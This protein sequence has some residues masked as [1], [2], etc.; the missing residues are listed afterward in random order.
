M[1]AND[2][3][4]PHKIAEILNRPRTNNKL[5]NKQGFNN[6]FLPLRGANKQLRDQNTNRIFYNGLNLD[7]IYNLYVNKFNES[8]PPILR[9]KPLYKPK[10]EL[11]TDYPFKSKMR[12]AEAKTTNTQFPPDFQLKPLQQLYR[13]YFSPNLGSWEIDIVVAPNPLVK[14]MNIY[15][16]FCVNINTKY[17]IVYKVE[18]RDLIHLV[19][20]I[21]KLIK[22]KYVSNIRGDGELANIKFKGINIYSNSQAN[23]N[24]NR[25]VDR[26]IRTVRDAVGLD[27]FT[28]ENNIQRVVDFYNK[29]PHNSLRYNNTLYTPEQVE[30]S[31]DL[32]GLFI[33]KNKQ[34]LDVVIQ[35]QKKAGLF[36]YKTGNI[37]LVHLDLS[38]TPLM[39]QK[40]RRTFNN[41]AEFV[42]YDHGN[43]RVKIINADDF[44]KQTVGEIN[45]NFDPRSQTFNIKKTVVLPIY[46]TK[47]VCDSIGN[48]PAVYRNYFF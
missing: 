32:E 40:V 43:V 27:D 15:Y 47:Y 19:P 12:Y 18:S 5:L 46:Y 44:D 35:Q 3:D 48:L 23:T 28:D 13:P 10:T 2:F 16:L 1:P 17:L 42:K 24:H 4:K 34:L 7:D 29:A 14:N 39:F 36:D 41:L 9:R 33:R 45:K 26:V 21:N 6:L 22:Y 38:R 37:L 20:A 30:N 11:S 25:V 8:H 31:K